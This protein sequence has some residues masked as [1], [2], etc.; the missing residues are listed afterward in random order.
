MTQA[1]PA[2]AKKK[3]KK[4][5]KDRDKTRQTKFSS[6]K[7]TISDIKPYSNIKISNQK[8]WGGGK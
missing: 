4:F 1:T 3:K 2:K 7:L 8:V 5:K 6:E